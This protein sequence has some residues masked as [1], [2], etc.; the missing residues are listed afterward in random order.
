[1]TMNSILMVAILPLVILGITLFGLD[2]RYIIDFGIALICLICLILMRTNLSFRIIPI[3]PSAFYGAYCVYLISVGT[4]NWWTAVWI[5]AFPLVAIFLCQMFMGIMQSL[6]VLGGAIF[7]M[8]SSVGTYMPPLIRTRI[9]IAYALI[10]ALTIIYERVSMLK[11]NKESA[12]NAQLSHERDIVQTMKD[13][14]HQGIFLM[15][16]E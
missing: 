10:L 11:D 2:L 3:I 14:I 13:N 16:E 1:M 4:E 6:A 15:D 12:L 5:F 8:Y 9:I 7:I